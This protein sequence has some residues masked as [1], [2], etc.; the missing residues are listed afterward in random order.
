M[1][2]RLSK[3]SVFYAIL[4]SQTFSREDL[5][6]YVK[7]LDNPTIAEKIAIDLC[8]NAADGKKDAL[9]RYWQI[10]QKNQEKTQKSAQKPINSSLL[11]DILTEVEGDVF[12]NIVEGE[13]VTPVND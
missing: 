6:Q 10:L 7:T 4:Y 11:D 8:L 5:E 13:E 9:D 2:K 3:D 12:G 1:T